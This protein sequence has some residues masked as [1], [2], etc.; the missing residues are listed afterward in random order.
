VKR[1]LTKKFIYIIAV[2]AILAMM[3]PAMTVPVS[4]QGG[5][6]L[7]MNL[8]DPITQA[9]QTT[10]DSGFN[11]TG[12]KVLLTVA[13]DNG[14]SVVDWGKNNIAVAPGAGAAD[15]VTP[16]GTNLTATATGTWGDVE[17]YVDLTSATANASPN[18]E[19]KFGQIES[20]SITPPGYS[21]VTWVEA[22]KKWTGST[23]ITDT[24]TGAFYE[25]D[26][27]AHPVDPSRPHILFNA[28]Q[29]V[30]LN[31]YL[32]AGNVAV[33]LSS[34][35]AGDLKTRMAGYATPTHVSFAT[36]PSTVDYA[37]NV[38]DANGQNGVTLYAAG[39]EAVQVVVVPEYPYDS[40]NVPVT[41]EITTY[42]FY[43]TE[44]EVVPQVRWAG[45][46]IV[47]EKNFGSTYNNDWVKFDLQN[48]SVGSLEGIT[49]REN[50]VNATAVWTQVAN[51]FASVIL[52]SSDDGVANVTAG[53]YT[54]SDGTHLINQH[55][56]TVYFLKFESVVLGD[57]V[58]KRAGHDSGVWQTGNTTQPTNPWDPTGSYNGTVSPAIPDTN[59]QKLN[60]SQ[61]A[62]L[63]ARVRGWFVSANP[64]TRPARA[65]DPS[66]SDV[67]DPNSPTLTL[68]QYRWVLPDDW[69][70][71]AGPNWQQSRLH[72]DIMCNPD[73]SVG[74]T[75]DGT[76]VYLMPPV[77]GVAVSGSPV[78]GPFSP[79]LEL[80]TPTG[81]TIPNPGYDSNRN[82]QTVVPDG[83]LNYWDAPMP[84]AKVIF[85]IQPN[86]D[87]TKVAGFFKA[88][89]K[90]DVYYILVPDPNLNNHTPITVYTNPFYQELIPAHE[91]IPAFINNGGYDWNSFDSS[92]GPYMFW[93]FINQHTYT[94]MVPTSD[95]SGHPTNVEVYS[96]N[97]GEAM[98]WLNGNWN[99]DLSTSV[100][101]GASVDIEPGTTVAFSTVQATADYPYSRDHQAFQSSMDTKEWTWGGQ[102]L[103]TDAHTYKN[104]TNPQFTTN[105]AD[106]RMVL[107]VG[108]YVDSSRIGVA[109]GEAAKSSSKMV[110]V[111]VTDRDGQ[112]A[113]VNGATVVWNVAN[114]S[115]SSIKIA[116]DI[117]LGPI[118]GYNT[119]TQNI[120]TQGGFLANTNG[121]VTDGAARLNAT[122][123]LRLPTPFE[124]QL[125]N[126]FW[127]PSPTPNPA[128]PNPGTPTSPGG[129]SSI[130]ADAT[131]YCVAALKVSGGDMD[132]SDMAA[133][134]ITVISHDF[135]S[136]I[137]QPLPGQ[138]S[139]ETDVDLSVWDALDDGIRV[140]DANCDGKVDIGDVTA[141]ENM[142]L[143]NTP[144]TSNAIVNNDGSVDMGTVVKIERTILGYK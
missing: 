114:R 131:K 32:I 69:A 78:K 44:A 129:T 30:V 47:L 89:N 12:S 99:L 53:L 58:G 102:V 40:L 68:P 62:L 33:D 80:M 139:Y 137:G 117:A 17:F 29:G 59:Y 133:V 127:G 113:G 61:D 142:I 39:E 46:K 110:W 25:K 112:T 93:Q 79:G 70:A 66:A 18:V 84:P 63:R 135:D 103:G 115:G 124:M 100:T 101:E 43:T 90:Q 91:A 83:K 134:N 77:I 87:T 106:T 11:V 86:S 121:L 1:T 34:G 82:I 48:Q 85:Q 88:T 71:L 132:F 31:W 15:Y 41:P 96:D 9:A 55:Y 6:T 138:V 119:V 144:I 64:S 4:A 21:P 136:V 22:G 42:D 38:S 120:F 118:S 8:I 108:N 111:W 37:Q 56:F 67:D 23:T 16:P 54:S 95:P 57:V 98:V 45:E 104:P 105:T 130:R 14:Y 60:I 27:L 73:G 24:V 49:G 65:V 81:W 126:K 10:A 97:H 5:G 122:S 52:T 140:G 76:N 143:G 72:W 19:K 20:T 36:Q 75:V 125:F 116:N 35:E 74:T 94:P 51:G 28:V 26:A 109:P 2:V 128:N 107:S 3:V 123:T 141:V 7:S 50:M 92:Y 13:P